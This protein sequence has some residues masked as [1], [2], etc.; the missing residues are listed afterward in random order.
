MVADDAKNKV[1]ALMLAGYAN[2]NL[3]DVIEW[4]NSGASSMINI[5]SYFDSNHDNSISKAEY[6]SDA[7]AASSFRTQAFGGAAFDLLDVN[8]DNA[9]TALDFGL[10]NKTRYQAILD[11]IERSDDEWIWKN[12]FHVTSAWLK[13]HFALEA[14][15]SRL[16]R[17][18]MPIYIFHGEDDGN[19][20]VEGVYDL[21][22]RFDKESKKNL[23]E[24]VFKNHN[25][26][27]NYLDWVKKGVIS[28][29]LE[30]LFQTAESL[31]KPK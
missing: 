20:P 21:R 24:V 11:A 28:E 26:D 18:K 12:Y 16:L 15:K 29:G 19:C 9:I 17:L 25:H 7:K 6:E 10:L 27:L 30:K 1:A 8:K 13:E 22:A 3:R 5:R 14:N 2:D 23:R 31:E 4:Q